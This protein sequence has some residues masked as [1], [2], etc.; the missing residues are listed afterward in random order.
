MKNYKVFYLDNEVAE[1]ESMKECN[2]YVESQLKVDSEL[3]IKDFYIY[4]LLG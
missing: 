3:S 4:C 1:F 2:E